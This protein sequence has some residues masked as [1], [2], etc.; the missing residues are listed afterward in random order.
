MVYVTRAARE[1]IRTDRVRLSSGR[2]RLNGSEGSS[3]AY[4]PSDDADALAWFEPGAIGGALEADASTCEDADECITLV[5]LRPSGGWGDS[6]GSPGTAPVYD[7]DGAP[8][9]QGTIVANG[10]DEFMSVTVP[11]VSGAFEVWAAASCLNNSNEAMFSIG[12]NTFY[13]DVHSDNM[14]LGTTSGIAQGAHGLGTGWG[15]WRWAARGDGT[16]FVEVNGVVVADSS[17]LDLSS[18]TMWQ[19]F[20]R[21]T[22]YGQWQ[23]AS[24]IARGSVASGAVEA[25]VLS[26]MTAIVTP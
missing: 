26:Y 15:V 11:G 8:N 23:L 3:P 10:T 20:R 22:N 6:T 2:I 21:T 5:N 16:G 12:G 4:S 25:G 13:G 18:G 24:M 7:A 9:G 19:I 17:I 14:R 1:R